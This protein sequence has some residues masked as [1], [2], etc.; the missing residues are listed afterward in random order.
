MISLYFI[1]AEVRKRITV[2]VYGICL[3]SVLVMLI[4]VFPFDWAG[5]CDIRRPLCSDRLCSVS[6]N[7]HIAWEVPL[8][9]IGN[10]LTNNFNLPGIRGGFPTYVLAAVL[11]PLLYG[12]WRLTLYHLLLGPILARLTTDNL[13]EFPAVW[14]LLS[15]GILIIVVKTPLRSKFH[16]KNW[17]WW[18]KSWR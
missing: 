18:P 1:P 8:N 14:C 13:N 5:Q 3:F 17:F 15:I 10:H 16:V 7:W 11:L 12:S 9:G 6:G 2:W 4:Q